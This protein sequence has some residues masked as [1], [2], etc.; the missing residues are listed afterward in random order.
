MYAPC[1][2]N[3]KKMIQATGRSKM[4][5]MELK[6]AEEASYAVKMMVVEST[7]S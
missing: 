5:G 2:K 1:L 6:G 7:P 4:S 3:I